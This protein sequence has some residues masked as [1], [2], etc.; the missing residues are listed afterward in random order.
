M[1]Q[2]SLEE[3]LENPDR[4]LV[5]RDGRNVR[6]ICTDRKGVGIDSPYPIVALIE[7]HDEIETEAVMTFS[8]EGRQRSKSDSD[9]DLFF[10]PKEGWINIYKTKSGCVQTGE[11]VVYDSKEEAEAKGKRCENYISTIKIE[12]EE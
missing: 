8:Y 2:F 3:Y 7:C 6:I 10:A 1:K 4:K 11:V 5:T 12:W 9:V